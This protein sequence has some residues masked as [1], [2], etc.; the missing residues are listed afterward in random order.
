MATFTKRGNR[1]KAQIRRAGIPSLS[2][3]FALKADAEAWARDKERAIDR[4]ELPA[5]HRDLRAITVAELLVRYRDTITPSKR[6]KATEGYMIKTMLAHEL[7]SVPLNKIS[8]AYIAKYRDDR[9]K[10]VSA[11]TVLRE[12]VLL[13]HMFNLA[14]KD[15]GIPISVNPVAGVTKPTQNKA[16]TRR[17]QEGEFEAL[18]EAFA[19]CRNPLVKPVILFA[20]ATGMRRGEIVS[21]KWENLDLEQRT[22]FLPITKNGEARHIPL[23]PVALGVVA[24]L[25]G[26][27]KGLVF[28][29][30]AN[31]VRLA[32]ERA[33]ARAGIK[34]LRFHDLRHEA[35]SRFFELGLSVPEVSLISG[36]KDPRMLARY[37][38]LKAETVAEKLSLL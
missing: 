15:W 17:L 21:L 14:I 38:H 35:V 24:A 30:S 19:K 31:A 37:T 2:K 7:A 9:R 12:F 23:S 34:G 26:T 11:S 32:W 25:E 13:S 4:S 8:P 22:A 3:T 20:L 33:R 29:I 36:H 6:A 1:W 5:N 28:P 10:L 16:R 27:R 18:C